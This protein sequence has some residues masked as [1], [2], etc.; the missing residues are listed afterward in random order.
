M[1]E[2][3]PVYKTLLSPVTIQRLQVGIQPLL[4]VLKRARVANPN[5]IEAD[6]QRIEAGFP[7]APPHKTPPDFKACTLY[8]YEAIQCRTQLVAI[9]QPCIYARSLLGD[10]LKEAEGWLLSQPEIA[11]QKNDALRREAARLVL[12]P[13]PTRRAIIKAVCERIDSFL[14]LLKDNQS[15][16]DLIMRTWNEQRFSE[17]LNG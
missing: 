15:A 3:D 12:E 13:W 5:Q 8:L 11:V 4:R 14:W 9:Q 10:G 6:L 17:S 7:K 16:V 1:S 2:A